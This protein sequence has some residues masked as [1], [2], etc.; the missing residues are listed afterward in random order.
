MSTAINELLVQVQALF[1]KVALLHRKMQDI[2]GPS[3]FVLACD[4][5]ALARAATALDEGAGHVSRGDIVVRNKL[6]N[7]ASDTR[8]LLDSC[9][10]DG[11]H[12]Y[13]LEPSVRAY[14]EAVQRIRR[15]LPDVLIKLDKTAAALR[16][17]GATEEKEAV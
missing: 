13:S 7:G 16:T 6:W 11:Q 15:R 14:H 9:L 17:L 1:G 5:S 4:L 8:D 12:L 3:K 10:T 2:P